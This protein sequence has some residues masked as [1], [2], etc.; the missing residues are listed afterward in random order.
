MRNLAE[1]LSA[2]DHE[3]TYLTR[4]QWESGDEPAIP[5]VRVIAV[6]PRDELYGRDGRRRIAPPLRF[7][8]GVLRHLARNRGAYDAVHTCAFPY[9]SLLATRLALTGTSVS[10]GVD[11]FEVWSRTYWARYLGPVGGT[12]GWAVQRAC[13][14]VTP[15]AFVF[16][17][18][19]SERLRE[20]G[21]RSAPIRLAGL[22]A[23]SKEPRPDHVN[24]PLVVFAGRHI[25]E[26][27]APSV[28]AAVMCARRRVPELRGLI[29]GDG[30]ERLKVVE[31]IAASN[32][33]GVVA[34]PGFVSADEVQDALARA[35]CLLLPSSREGYG[36]VVIEA[37]AAGTPSVV[38]AG[39]DNAAVE[40]VEDGVN[41][42]LA[43][44]EH[45][46]AIADAVV[47]CI[48]GGRDLRAS[49]A[50]W[51]ARRAP[52]LSLARSAEQLLAEYA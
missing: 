22:Y 52:E 41:G 32:A 18:L 9:F 19:H 15:K 36:L 11:W 39:P 34:A 25:A 47:R 44:S 42:F 12:I 3:V 30:P 49:T 5:G 17:H 6:S 29:L 43:A 4:Q 2:E 26:K 35:S 24:A 14:L 51:F 20:E 37:A 7:G 31:A 23:G 48:D 28:P 40:L 38:V 50:A 10:I 45:P 46:E 13:V 16:S 33:H 27:R 21:L 8:V 1:R